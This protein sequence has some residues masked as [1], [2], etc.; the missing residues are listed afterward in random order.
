MNHASF[1][2]KN[3]KGKVSTRKVEIIEYKYTVSHYHGDEEQL[4]LI[5]FDLD[6]QQERTYLVADII[7][8]E[9]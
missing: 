6:K 3:W 2:Y 9:D 8:E 1:L 5:G 7:L 4:F